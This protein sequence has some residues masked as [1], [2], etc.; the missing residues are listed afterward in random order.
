MIPFIVGDTARDSLVVRL[1]ACATSQPRIVLVSEPA[2]PTPQPAEITELIGCC[3]LAHYLAEEVLPCAPAPWTE[4]SPLVRL[5]PRWRVKP[6]PQPTRQR[7]W[8][9]P[10]PRE[11]G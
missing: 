3:T 4:L 8:L 7:R 1:L 6:N 2:P 9:R 5:A 11:A 10:P